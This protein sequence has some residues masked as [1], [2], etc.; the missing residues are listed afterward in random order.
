MDRK[1]IKLYLIGAIAMLA[2]VLTVIF[3]QSIFG[4]ARERLTALIKGDKNITV[5][6]DTEAINSRALLEKYFNDYGYETKWSDTSA[7]QSAY[8]DMLIAMLNQADSLGLDRNDYHQDYLTKFDSLSHLRNFDASAYEEEN[9]LIFTDAAISFLYHVAYGKE[10]PRIAYNGVKYNIDTARIVSVFGGLMEHHDWRRALDSIEPQVAQYKLLKSEL[11]R[12]QTFVRNYP[13]ID[14][15]M[16]AGTDTGR[17]I[18]MIRLK[19]LGLLADTLS[20]DSVTAP[21]LKIAITGFQRMMSVDTTGVA[22]AKTIAMLNFPISQRLQQIKES[23]NYWR[24]TG[25]L[26]E[27]EFI[28]VNI[29]AARLQIVNHDSLKDMSMRVIV[30][31]KN[32]QTPSFTAYITRVITYPYWTV[33]ISIATKEMLPKIRKRVSYLEDNNLQVINNKG[34]E[35]DP[36][37]VNWNRYS[38]K[39]FP[40]TLR[41]STGCDNA[42][43]VLKFDLNSPYSVYLHDTNRRDLFGKKDRF[44]S[45]GCV[46]VEKPM[47]LAQYVLNNGLDS[48]TVAKLDQCV[49]DQT[50]TDFLLKKKFPVL[51]LY[52][53]ADVD[54]YMRLKFYNDVY[55]EPKKAAI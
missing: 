26:N 36:H 14:A 8:R 54:E 15:M 21:M 45:H 31:K 33:P 27:Q 12:M 23:L 25:R 32:T 13:Q 10:I 37:T 40:F 48:L 20:N 41:Q 22:D 49:R 16:A 34:Q 47:E 11:N 38:E 17:S 5:Q 46:R 4:T 43:G 19:A 30:G 18:T 1:N 6:G 7:A 50:P 39:Y 52:M 24:W 44:M 42:L 29:P 3:R 51:L 35:V 28:L 53:T 2:I 9:E 55:S